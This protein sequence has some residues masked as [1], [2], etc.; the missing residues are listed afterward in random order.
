MNKKTG[1]MQGRLLP[2]YQGRYQAHPVGY[3]KDEFSIAS[4]LGLDSIEFILDYNDVEENPLLTTNGLEDISKIEK[5]SGVKVRS[6]CADYFM[7][8]P[9]HSNDVVIVDSSINI[10]NRLIRNAS[11]MNV[12]DIVVPCVDQSSLKNEKYKKNFINNIKTV[13]SIAEDANI[14]ISI[15]S[16]LAPI[17]LANMI[18]S[19]GSKNV[20]VNY[21]IGNSAAL[22]YNPVEEFRAYGDKISDLH[23]KDRLLGKG[24]V[25]LGE[26]SADILKVFEL[27]SKNDYQGLIIFQAFRDDEGVE[28]FKDQLNW[29]LKNVKL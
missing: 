22:G 17:P 9:I 23:I 14:N 13:V 16:D 1:I 2:K 11:L 27:L 3:W 25:P 7:E 5:I 29:F 18:D 15:E 20:T 28:I 24:P 8:A 19:I 6:I 26:G 21:D 10:L 12:K 4:K